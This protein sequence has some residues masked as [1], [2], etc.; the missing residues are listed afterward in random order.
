ME[1]ISNVEARVE[2]L[3]ANDQDL[4]S[5]QKVG[6]QKAEIEVLRDKLTDM[7]DRSR[8]N[9]LR[10][11]GIPEGSEGTDMEVF[12]EQ[13]LPQL[14]GI[15]TLSHGWDIE[16]AHRALT[17]WPQLNNRSWAVIARLMHSR[18]R[19]LIL[20]VSREKRQLQWNGNSVLV[21]PDFSKITQEKRN[22]FK[23]CKKALHDRQ[24]KFA[25]LFPAMLKIDL[26]DGTK[27]FNDPKK[28]LAFICSI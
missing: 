25:L 22:A 16:R 6:T 5:N 4:Q 1:R 10:F 12:L 19:D 26:K 2:F 20:R 24:I 18:T 27:R 8:R 15:P 13:I 11:V 23:Q 9:N 7:E 17:P 3:K 21:F 14:L 28:A